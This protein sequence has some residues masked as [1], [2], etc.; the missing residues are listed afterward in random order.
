VQEILGALAV[1]SSIITLHP[2]GNMDLEYV[3]T[4]LNEKQISYMQ[5]VPAYLSNMC[6]FLLK[7]DFQKLV[8][9][10]NIDIGGKMFAIAIINCQFMSFRRR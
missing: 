5:S 8:T 3:L 1:G 7:N 9:L 4:V 2:Q 6:D 10:R